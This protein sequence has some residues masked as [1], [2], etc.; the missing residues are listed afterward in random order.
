MKSNLFALTFSLLSTLLFSQPT[1]FQTRGTG[2]GGAMFSPAI[3]PLDGD[4]IYFASDLG[5]LYHTTDG[6]AHFDV[7]HFQEAISGPF[8]KVCFT[9]DSLIRYAILYDN[10]HFTDRPAKSTD[11]GLTWNFMPGDAQPDELKLF[12]FADRSN[13]NRVIWTDYNHLFFSNDGGQTASLKMT[14]ANSGTGIL[15][16]GA[17][18][19]G[20]KIWLGTNEGILQSLDGG[21]N[22]S[23]ANFPGIPAAEAIIG[24]GGAKQ[25]GTMRFFAL[26]GDKNEVWA[27]SL[28]LDSW[29]GITRG[30][31]SLD[32]AAGTWQLKTVGLNF[33]ND[34]LYWLGMAENDISTCWLA[35]SNTSEYPSVVRTTNAGASWQHIFLTNLNQNIFTS[36]AGAGGDF[37]WGWAGNSLGFAVN[38]LNAQQA[39]VTDF[40]FLHQTKNGGADWHQI[41][42]DPADE[43]PKGVNTPQKETYTGIGM[44][45]T[46][47]WQVFHFDSLNLFGCY[48]DI[49]GMRSTDGGH[50]WSFDYN[51]H[52]LNTMYRIVKQTGA[53]RWFGGNSSIHDIYQTTYITDARLFPSFS[54]G[55]VLWTTDKGMNWQLMRDFNRP[56][57]WLA[58]DPNNSE[59][60]YVAVVDNN[61]ANGGLWRADGISNPASA[62]WTKI[63]NPPANPG[64]I[65]NVHILNDGTIVT[66]WSAKKSDSGSTFSNQSG[67]FMSQNGGQTWFDRSHASMKYWTK[68]LVIDPFDPLQNTWYACIW[69][70]WGGPANDLGR[71]WRTTNRGQ[72]WQPMTAAGQ[73][74]RVSSV[75]ID[76]ENSET[77]YLTTEGEG[78]WITKNKSAVSPTWELVAAYP[79]HH[80]ERVFFNPFRPK[81][82]W[83]AS[84]GNGMRVAP[85]C[86]LTASVVGSA[87]VCAGE[88]ATYSTAVFPNA[89]YLWTVS[90]GQIVSGQG[91]NSIQVA[92]NGGVVGEVS[93]VVSQ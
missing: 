83:V 80:V 39:V 81:E 74:L 33:G 36:Y 4:E 78:L 22:F 44:E 11:G 30:L 9:A 65:F 16:S 55:Q 35:G 26:T 23:L 13:P 75:T 53:D 93:V 76:P 48:T 40:G 87:A 25:G 10:S 8:S 1:T 56:V 24:F 49:R 69:S 73:F 41:Y 61:S 92:W 71:L 19:D 12:I 88:L 68:D 5:G 14:A 58:T 57:I 84:F 34:F 70:G 52:S 85:D 42:S 64:R 38:P 32:N 67:V 86:L 51:G 77:M 28:G 89:T 59:R 43:H 82:M 63:S 18:F 45:Q 29:Y 50:D 27:R 37:N 66:T 6:A 2:G 3:N 54:D 91:T 15:L 90:G 31:Y 7:V 72:S 17:F 62:V 79:F 21:Q 60:L 46:T 20:Q 47:C